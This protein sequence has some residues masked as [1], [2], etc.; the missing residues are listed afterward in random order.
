MNTTLIFAE[1][2]IIGLQA[3]IWLFLLILG[4]FG[5]NWIQGLVTFGIADWQTVIVVV[6]LSIVYVLGVIVDRLADFVFTGWDKKIRDRTYPNL[7]LTLGVMRFQLGKDNEYLN[8]QF[9]YTRS[10]MRIARASSLN[11][12][13][14]TVLGGWL[15][16][17]LQF[18]STAEKTKFIATLLLVGGSLS[19][20]AIYAWNKLSETYIEQVKGN[21]EFLMSEKDGE[22]KQ[23]RTIAENKRKTPNKPKKG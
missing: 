4:I 5:T 12:L 20:S 1:L 9:E 2:L 15:I 22:Q 11:F 10:R 21:W 8:R 23:S 13:L 3:S 18:P 6:A 14:I 16:Y 7:P 17:H 19:G